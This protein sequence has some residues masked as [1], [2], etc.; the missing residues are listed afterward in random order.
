[1]NRWTNSGWLL[2]PRSAWNEAVDALRLVLLNRLRDAERPNPHSTPSVERVVMQAEL[3]QVIFT[4][5][6]GEK[7]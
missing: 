4:Y 3:L 6:I 1:M 7:Q 5:Q 2:V